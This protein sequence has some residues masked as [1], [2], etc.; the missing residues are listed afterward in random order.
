MKAMLARFAGF[1][2]VPMMSAVVPLLVLPIAS[3]ID[4]AA[5]WAA[6]GTG[7][8]IGS[9]VAM[10]ASYGWNVNGGA[11]VAQASDAVMQKEIYAQS[12]W[13]RIIAYAVAGT[14]GAILAA[15][16][17]GGEFGVV[18]ALAA[19]ATGA[20][21]L[22]VAWYSVGVGRARVA[23]WYE[24]IPTAAF[25]LLSSVAMLVTGSVAAYPTL[26]LAGIVGGLILLNLHLYRAVVPPLDPIALRA[27]FRSNFRLAVADGIG[28]SYTTAP[29]PIGQAVIG[30]TA[31]AQLT[32]ADKVYRIGVT[33]I[34]VLANSLQKWVL[35]VSFVDGRM[36]RHVIALTLHAVLGVVG[37]MVLTLAGAPLTRLLLGD[38]V[39]PPAEV[40]PAYGVTFFIISMTTPLIRN[41][42]VPA[43]GDRIVMIAIITS[44]IVG[45]PAMV[46]AGTTAGL[47]GIVSGL[48][49]SEVIVLTF[50][51][52]AAIGVL[53]R[54]R[55]PR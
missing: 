12:F 11:R 10:V 5:G 3:R 14:A 50:V 19:L 4:G 30:T 9:F 29:V 20:T 25:T 43:H 8:A 16:L 49:L 1:G 33:A 17:I 52:I 32:S 35:E 41:V 22:T 46:I 2:A 53:R 51:S 27:A 39:T 31:A 18:A 36:R 54:E 15:V 24:A 44:A 6:I 38:D 23:L 42:L 34:A 7:Q 21:G 48:V 47:L 37:F 13:S 26:M 45:L 40:F 28:G 55:I